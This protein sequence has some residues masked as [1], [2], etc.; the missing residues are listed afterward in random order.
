MRVGLGAEVGRADG[1]CLQEF[2]AQRGNRQIGKSENKEIEML[3]GSSLITQFVLGLP[4]SF[5]RI[6]RSVEKEDEAM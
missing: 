1:S 6:T 4:C 5:R 3:L 2:V